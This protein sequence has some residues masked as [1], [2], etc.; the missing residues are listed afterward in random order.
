MEIAFGKQNFFKIIK[1]EK[2]LIK[3]FV[4]GHDWFDSIILYRL[5]DDDD[6]DHHHL[7]IVI[8]I[9]TIILFNNKKI[10]HY[11]YGSLFVFWFINE[12]QQQN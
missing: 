9:M 5:N 10:D 2:N 4:G 3:I 1:N 12:R 8:Q 7:S 6:T 11:N